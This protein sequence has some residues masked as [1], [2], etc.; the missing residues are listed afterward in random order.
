VKKSNIEKVQNWISK[1]NFYEFN[2]NEINFSFQNSNKSYYVFRYTVDGGRFN[3]ECFFASKIE[4]NKL[5]QDKMDNA[6]WIELSIFYVKRNKEV[7]PK[8]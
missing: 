8:I 3:A 6:N 5:I 4:V 2:K 7:Y 1:R